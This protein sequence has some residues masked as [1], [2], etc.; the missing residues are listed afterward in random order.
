MKTESNKDSQIKDDERF[1]YRVRLPSF[2]IDKEMGLGDVVKR[3]TY[4]IGIKPCGRC[5]K[6]AA[7][8]NRRIVFTR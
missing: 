6:R 1:A 4:K 3:V 8:L 7:V 5:E 2:I